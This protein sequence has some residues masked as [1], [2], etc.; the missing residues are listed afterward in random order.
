MKTALLFISCLAFLIGCSQ[1]TNPP[2]SNVNTNDST[3]QFSYDYGG[4]H[5][6]R[7]DY[8]VGASASAE[9]QSYP[10][11]GKPAIRWS[12]SVGLHVT[13]FSSSGYQ[14]TWLDLILSDVT[15]EKKTYT[16]DN[17]QTTAGAVFFLNSTS[18]KTTP[19]GT[20]TITKFDTLNN[21]VSG[22]FSFTVANDNNP[23]DQYT[24]SNGRFENVP[25]SNGSFGQGSISANAEGTPFRAFTSMATSISA[26]IP[27][28]S[29]QM[30]ITAADQR[31]GD[32]KI[33]ILN[34]DNP[35]VGT[36][37]L[38]GTLNDYP[39][40]IGGNVIMYAGS[41]VISTLHKDS[42]GE[43]TITKFDRATHRISGTF[44]LNGPSE[45]GLNHSV[46]DGVI[47]NVQWFVP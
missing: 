17:T 2:T 45:D 19:G 26:L 29:T 24:I 30:Q 20:I 12:L 35:R 5:I 7:K 14:M 22:T 4:K 39:L 10:S 21:L 47:D 46:T 42:P 18:Y 38:S 33:L 23:T 32:K 1:T 28:G 6:A 13:A 41:F 36:F 3:S 25:I 9:V 8:A 31:D 11:S 34:F 37:A 44:H 15:F 43:L 27:S 40:P 16:I